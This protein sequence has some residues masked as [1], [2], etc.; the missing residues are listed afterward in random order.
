MIFN[1]NCSLEFRNYSTNFTF[2]AK[3]C[4]QSQ[5]FNGKTAMFS[6]NSGAASVWAMIKLFGKEI[7]SIFPGPKN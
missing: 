6:Y 7:N 4:F 1:S 5:I 2:I 3:F